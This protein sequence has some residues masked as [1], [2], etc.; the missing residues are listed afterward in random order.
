MI[1]VE[2]LNKWL[3]YAIAGNQSETI[4]HT[5]LTQKSIMCL[6]SIFTLYPIHLAISLFCL[7]GLATSEASSV[8]TEKSQSKSMNL[9][10]VH[11]SLAY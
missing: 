9:E 6:W 7:K 5:L 4:E 11:Q 8:S 10:A 2:K 3:V 1:S